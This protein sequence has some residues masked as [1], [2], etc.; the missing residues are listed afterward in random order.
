M[1]E[2]VPFEVVVKADP[3]GS[4]TRLGRT[5]L[6]DWNEAGSVST[7]AVGWFD[8]PDEVLGMAAIPPPCCC[9]WLKN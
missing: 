2:A 4:L 3:F 1:D 5:V 9:C 6:D 8:P 7:M